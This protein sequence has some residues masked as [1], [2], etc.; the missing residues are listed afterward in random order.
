MFGLDNQVL[1]RLHAFGKELGSSRG[2][3]ALELVSPFQNISVIFA[4]HILC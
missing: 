4:H 1:A 3:G 2:Q